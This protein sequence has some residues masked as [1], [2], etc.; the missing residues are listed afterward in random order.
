VRIMS[1]HK[2]KGLEFDTVIVLGVEKQT[3]WGEEEAERSAY[4]VAIS[5]A[6]RR[7]FLTVCNQRERPDGVK[8]WDVNRTEH[9]EFIGYAEPYL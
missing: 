5:R 4:F 1:I 9:A 8:R 6:K 7:L 3:F 2:S